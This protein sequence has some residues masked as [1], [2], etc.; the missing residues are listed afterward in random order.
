M[1]GLAEPEPRVDADGLIR[2]EG[3]AVAGDFL[4]LCDHASNRVPAGFGSPG[5]PAAQMQRHIAWDP[6]ALPVA[7][8]MARRLGSPLVFPDASRLLIDCNRPTDAPDSA[9]TLSEDTEI[10]GNVDLDPAVRA[11]R[12]AG[13]YDAYHDAID[14][15][16]DRR[17]AAGIDTALAA[18]HSYT[19]TYRSSPRPWHVGILYNADRR[20]ADRLFEALEGEADLVVGDNEP[21]GPWDGVYH[22]LHRHGEARGLASVMIEIRND[23][24]GEAEGQVIWA[25]RL[26]AALWDGVRAIR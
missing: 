4:V 3:D 1:N 24:I 21:Y 7:R 13:I 25:E 10:P 11:H 12:I 2:L 18:V 22:T 14:A 19:P 17:A 8:D 26:A 6:G 20:L 5:L 23:L 9:T 16:L 15:L